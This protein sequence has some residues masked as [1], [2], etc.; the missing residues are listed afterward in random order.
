MRVEFLI[1]SKRQQI[2]KE[3]FLPDP[4]LS[5]AARLVVA[6]QGKEFVL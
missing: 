2:A 6:H 4:R 3:S 5:Y 1:K